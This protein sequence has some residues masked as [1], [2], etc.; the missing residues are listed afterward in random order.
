MVAI[1]SAA[2]H[3]LVRAVSERYRATVSADEKGRILDE[4][5]SPLSGV[6][7]SIIPRPPASDTAAA[8][9]ARAMYVMG[10]C[11]TG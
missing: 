2:R 7:V 9:S 11:T 8:S 3:E 4:F 10:A 5:G 1:S 6:R